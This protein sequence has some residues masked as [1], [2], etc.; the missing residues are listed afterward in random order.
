MMEISRLMLG[1]LKIWYR[2]IAQGQY[3]HFVAE[4]LENLS[5]IG[6]AGEGHEVGVAE[7][8]VGGVAAP[9]TK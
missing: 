6:V 9:P 7:A 4:K 8:K 5:K 2:D 3:N 1:N